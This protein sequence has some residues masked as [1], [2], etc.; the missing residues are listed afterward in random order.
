MTTNKMHVNG[1]WIDA[2]DGRTHM[3][4]NPA[5]GEP[6]GAF[7]LGSATVA[8]QALDAAA[9]AMPAWAARPAVERGRQ[10]RRVADLLRERI[11][12][13]ARLCTQEN[14]KCIRESRAE[15]TGAAAHFDWFAEEGQRVYGRIVAPATAGKRHLV[16]H[17][18]VGVTAA[19]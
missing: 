18:P 12:P 15:V 3:A 10:L 8:E 17:Q 14:G 2:P 7:A 5:T 9:K 19:V 1:T 13:I 4:V 6:L 11:E 16:I